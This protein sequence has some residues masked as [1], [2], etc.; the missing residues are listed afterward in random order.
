MS[1]H[2]SAANL[3]SPGGD[4][5]LDLTDL[6]AFTAPEDPG[7]TVLIMDSDPFMAGSEYHPDAVY[8]INVDSGGDLLADTAFSF[9]FSR[10]EDGPQA[11]T[12]YLATGSQARRAEPTGDVIVEDMPVSFGKAA[13]P[14][15]AGPVR[16][17]V[18]ERSDPFFADVDGF[19]HG[20]Q[21]TGH[22]TFAGSNILSIALEVPSE[23]LGSDPEIGIWMT[24]SLRRDGQLVQMD[25]GGH[26]AMNPI[27]NPDDIKNRY[28]IGEP[29]T[30]VANYLPMWTMILQ[31]TGGYSAAEAE[32]TARTV[33]PD[34]LR[35]DRN[36]PAT[37]PNGR[38]LTDDVF[39]AR[40]H[41]L[42]NGKVSSDGLQPH[43]DLTAQ[44]P[45]LGP[46]NP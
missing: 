28:D 34:I 37:Y 14:I 33:L 3:R 6:Y 11:A 4:A 40:M 46:P 2:F 41:F 16:M 9:T 12:G 7:K 45:Y 10:P 1:N 42:T 31:Q 43:G 36:K 15:Q 18:G 24:V 44:F 30:D 17:F 21:W 22:D 8:K 5:R 26:P 13:I 29:A 23:L 19:L 38:N 39:S 25:R 27:V 32:A 20:Y 35:Y